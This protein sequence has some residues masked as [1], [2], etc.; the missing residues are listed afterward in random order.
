MV[1]QDA[2][3]RALVRIHAA[4][5]AGIDV[6]TL[7]DYVDLRNTIDKYTGPI[8]NIVVM[9][10]QAGGLRQKDLSLFIA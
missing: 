9:V 2:Y 1:S 8:T 4:S 6:T 5:T 3:F 10:D 7:T